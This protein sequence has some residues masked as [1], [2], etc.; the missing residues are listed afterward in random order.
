LSGRVARGPLRAYGDRWN[1]GVVQLSFTLPI[2]AG[3][4]ATEAARRYASGMG[5]GEPYVAL[6]QPV[7]P[8]FT[9]FVVYG[10]SAQEVDPAGFDAAEAPAPELSREEIDAEI[11]RRFAR[12]LVVLGCALESDAHTVGLDAI[13]NPKG[14]AGDPGLERY[15][16]LDARNLGAQ[17]P[18]ERLA[19]LARECG[20]DALL[21]SAT[22]TQNEIHIRHLT[23]LVDLLEAERLRDRLVLV[24]GGARVDHAL[25]KELGFDAGFGPGT[26]ARRVAAFLLEEVSRRRAAGGGTP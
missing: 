15:R 21:V 25:A 24:A 16:G 8:E 12:R 7:A 20:A 19:R 17:V 2:P 6:T 5:L 23:D 18:I 4:L 11:E 1:D 13:F 22:V 9:F 10:K 3:A 14:Y 26:T